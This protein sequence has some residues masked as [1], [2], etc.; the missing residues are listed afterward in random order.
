MTLDINSLGRSIEVSEAEELLQQANTTK[1]LDVRTPAEYE[2]LHIP[3]S[4]NVPLD[5]LPEHRINL[6]NKLNDPIIL[7][8]RSG[9]RA[10]QAAK[11]FEETEL[12]QFH[13]LRGGI[14]A[15]EKAGKPVRR[16]KQRWSMERQVR[17][18]AGALVLAGTLGGVFIWKPLIYLAAFI[19][20]GLAYSAVTDTCG[21][22]MLLSKLPY[23]SSTTCDVRDVVKQMTISES[24][25][26]Q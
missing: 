17:G 2:A 22:A 23:N 25:L 5:Q 3:G 24:G 15:W 21:M 7:L 6:G 4:Y 9:A 26:S 18:L 20:G 13:V 14:S 11:L 12:A 1:I 10:E 19:G 16:G 8:C